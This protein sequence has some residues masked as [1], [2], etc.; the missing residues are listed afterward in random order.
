MG[1]NPG[2]WEIGNK[3]QL[4]RKSL[5]MLMETQRFQTFFCLKTEVKT[6]KEVRKNG[7]MVRRN[8]GFL[9]G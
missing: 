6:E 2:A 3:R 1:D 7:K 8:S 9:A 5:E 4:S